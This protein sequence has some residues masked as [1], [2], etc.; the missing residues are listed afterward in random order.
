MW[1]TQPQ[2]HVERRGQHAVREPRVACEH[3]VLVR[4]ESRQAVVDEVAQPGGGLGV[5]DR[6]QPRAVAAGEIDAFVLPAVQVGAD[7][8]VDVVLDRQRRRRDV[9]AAVCRWRLAVVG[10]EVPPAAGRFA[11]VHEHVVQD[12]GMAVEVL[13]AQPA[14]AVGPGGEL[15]GAGHEAARPV[16]GHPGRAQQPP[17]GPGCGVAGVEWLAH[18]GQRLAVGLRAQV[19][20]LFAELG[21]AV[22]Q[23]RQDQVRLLAVERA[24]AEHRLGLDEQHRLVGGVEEMRSQL[25]GEQ[26]AAHAAHCPVLTRRTAAFRGSRGTAAAHPRGVAPQP[27]I[28]YRPSPRTSL[29]AF[30]L[31]E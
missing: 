23:R 6:E 10:V 26:P 9:E 17:G 5:G 11:A 22:A 4:A 21:G 18:L 19:P 12:P 20:R 25:I 24:A 7:L 13:Q 31:G 3:G 30:G 14:P 16:H 28:G 1:C 27:P 29:V 8:R 15:G 2:A